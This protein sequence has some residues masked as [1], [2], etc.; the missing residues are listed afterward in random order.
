M[1]TG[2]AVVRLLKKVGLSLPFKNAISTKCYPPNQKLNATQN[3]C[4]RQI[5][6]SKDKD[7]TRSC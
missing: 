7:T 1:C 3:V 6:E 4:E 5:A 2:V